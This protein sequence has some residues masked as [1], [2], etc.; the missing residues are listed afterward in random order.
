VVPLTADEQQRRLG[1]DV[2]GAGNESSSSAVMRASVVH[3]YVWPELA[4]QSATATVSAR[5][6]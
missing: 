1:R 5:P 3:G 6:G 2:C 4:L